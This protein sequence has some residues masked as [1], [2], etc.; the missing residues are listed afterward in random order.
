[1]K[2]LPVI[3]LILLVPITA[4]QADVCVK[5]VSHTDGYYNGGMNYPPEDE[6]SAMWISGDKMAVVGAK[7]SVVIDSS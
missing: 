5:Q 4:A 6:D 7:R 3:F 1:M 2:V